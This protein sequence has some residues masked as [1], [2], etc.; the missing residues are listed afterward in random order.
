M[1]STR[2]PGKMNH[3]FL[4]V[5][6]FELILKRLSPL[7]DFGA[8]IILATSSKEIEKP[9]IKIAHKNEIEVFKGNENDVFSRFILVAEHYKEKEIFIR[10]CGDNPFVDP[11]LIKELYK[12]HIS[13]SGL[14][15]SWNHVPRNNYNWPDGFGGECISRSALMR[16]SK[17]NL[18]KQELEHVTL[19]FYT[20][21]IFVSKSYYP[22]NNF[23]SSI[24][25]DID[26]PNQARS[27][28]KIIKK[29]SICWDDSSYTI[30]EKINE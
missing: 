18:S 11:I 7:Q 5:P 15:Y 17:L 21:D 14:D 27:I 20:R 30:L 28:E 13:N 1:G 4:G 9:L 3:K 22:D 12:F 23:L 6:L 29:Y 16:A 10:I 19:C 8:K 25:F 2:F 26:E 24:K